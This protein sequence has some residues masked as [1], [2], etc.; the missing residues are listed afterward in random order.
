MRSPPARAKRLD[1]I[2]RI[3]RASSVMMLAHI[4]LS[5]GMR[6]HR[7]E[8]PRQS[9]ASQRVW[10]ERSDSG[11]RASNPGATASMERATGIV[12]VVAGVS[13]ALGARAGTRRA[14]VMAAD[15][16]TDLG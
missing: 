9:Q 11:E 16:N 7:G 5:R 10:E 3:I 8:R 14:R 13:R 1:R 12:S 15:G 2:D 4:V 6:G